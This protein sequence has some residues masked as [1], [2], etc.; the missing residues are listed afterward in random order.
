MTKIIYVL[1]NP[2]MPGL[3]KIGETE[4]LKTAVQELSRPPGI[5]I[6]F[7][8]HYACSVDDSKDVEKALLEVFADHRVSPKREFLRINPQRVVAMLKLLELQK[9]TLDQDYV[10]NPE[11]R[12]SLEREKKRRSNIDLTLIGVPPGSILYFTPNWG[13][14]IHKDITAEVIDN[15]RVKFR[16][17]VTSLS[18]SASIA[19][20]E[21]PGFEDLEYTISGPPCWV[22]EGETLSARRDR[23]ENEED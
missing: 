14:T 5:P 17:E 10:E 4:D 23:L 19:L 9:I 8:V 16:G 11:E 21:T 3:V 18:R 12:R 2:V 1:T 13:E 7:E 20:K 6:P 15:R 22:Y